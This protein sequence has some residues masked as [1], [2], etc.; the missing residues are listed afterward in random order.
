[1]INQDGSPDVDP[2]TKK[3]RSRLTNQISILP[4]VPFE[5]GTM[6]DDVPGPFVPLGVT[7]QSQYYSEENS[8]PERV[9]IALDECLKLEDR[10]AHA[11]QR[12]ITDGDSGRF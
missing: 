7:E 11:S 12:I 4:L 9:K 3:Q 2:L 8:I 10:L 6:M 1:V 5:A